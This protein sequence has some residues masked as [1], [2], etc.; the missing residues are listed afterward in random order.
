MFS[1]KIFPCL[2]T[3]LST[4][5]YNTLIACARTEWQCDYGQCISI[6]SRC[7]G[8]IDCPDDTSDETHCPSKFNNTVWNT[9]NM[10]ILTRQL[11]NN[12]V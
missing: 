1:N 2:L 4:D 9:Y 5:I 10:G 11:D 3:P 7:N 8:N 12:I 6:E